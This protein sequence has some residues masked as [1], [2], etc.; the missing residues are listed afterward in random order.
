M[1]F[2][3]GPTRLLSPRTLKHIDTVFREEDRATAR[4]LLVNECGNNLPFL[5]T[6]EEIQLERYRFAAIRL[7]CGS[8]ESLR[9]AIQLA[10]TDW[11]D[12]LV[13]AGFGD[14]TTAHLRWSP[15]PE[16]K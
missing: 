6:A 9:R 7:S 2:K 14:D 12:L 1:S 8:V 3:T 15:T 10:K 11:R 4:E 5:E 13:A 16:K